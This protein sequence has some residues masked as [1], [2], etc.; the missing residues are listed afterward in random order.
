MRKDATLDKRKVR[1][2]NSSF[3]AYSKGTAYV[4]DYVVWND[5]GQRRICRYVARIA[6]APRIDNDPNLAGWMMIVVLS[7]NAASLWVRWVPPSE[8]EECYSPKDWT[9][10]IEQTM[11]LFNSSE[12]AKQ[13]PYDI[14]AQVGA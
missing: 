2:P 3:L 6:S 12:I 13:S 1:L 8:I 5:D 4:G 7:P 9:S 14:A 10:R 11:A